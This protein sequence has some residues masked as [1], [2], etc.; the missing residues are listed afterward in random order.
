VDVVQ[1]GPKELHEVGQPLETEFELRVEVGKM[2]LGE[3]GWA[4]GYSMR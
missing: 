3:A 1:R 4:E 2:F